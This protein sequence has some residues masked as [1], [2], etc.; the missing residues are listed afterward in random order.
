MQV[1]VDL[2]YLSSTANPAQAQEK[3][4]RNA[5][6]MFGSHE[7]LDFQDLE[8]LILGIENVHDKSQPSRIIKDG[9]KLIDVST[10]ENFK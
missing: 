5:F 6:G 10:P 3:L 4:I 2:N 1:M 7:V 9:R 8:L